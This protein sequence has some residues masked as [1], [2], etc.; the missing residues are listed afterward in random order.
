[1]IVI[2]GSAGFAKEVYLILVKIHSIKVQIECFVGADDDP[3]VG[4]TINNIPILSESVFFQKDKNYPIDAYIA[5]GSPNIKKKIIGKIEKNGIAANYPSL[6]DPSANLDRENNFINIG[7]G[8][9]ICG[10]ASLTIDI[11]IGDFTHLN[12][13]S[14][15]G[16]DVFIGKF[17]TISPGAN[18]SGKVR[19]G[20][21]SFLGTGAVILENIEITNGIVVGAGAVVA[22]NILEPGTYVGIPAKKLNYSH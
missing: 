4:Q 22:R 17:S 10:G 1:M 12:L 15:V 11:I 9:I 21:M 16:H 18:I 7:Q 5:V 14:T 3:S 20:N 19:I 2:F 8:V 6:I 13:N